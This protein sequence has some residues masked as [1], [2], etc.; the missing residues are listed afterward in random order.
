M[1]KTA[2]LLFLTLGALLPRIYGHSKSQQ[3]VSGNTNMD[4]M[5]RVAESYVQSV[6]AVG[7]HDPDYVD[8]YYGPKEW[9]ETAKAT[10]KLLPE[11]KKTATSLLADLNTVDPFPLEEMVQLRYQY[12]SKQI[13]SLIARID[14]LSGKQF[15]FDE[16][17]RA[18]YDAVAPVYPKSHYEEL[19]ERIS[20]KLPGEGSIR[21]RYLRFQKNFVIPPDRL[22]TVFQK[23]SKSKHD[24]Y[25][26]T[27]VDDALRPYTNDKFELRFYQ[28]RR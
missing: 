23:A 20:A 11:I 28:Y 7:E 2:V 19:L 27:T 13:Q 5:N 10:K 9:R 4:L 3:T 18:L 26:L 17:T 25:E 16:E 24:G 8:A 15:T 1:R 14:M 22:D 21:D 6:L 12:L